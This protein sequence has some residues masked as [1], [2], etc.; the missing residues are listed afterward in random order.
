MILY[1]IFTGAKGR[2]HIAENEQRRIN[3]QKFEIDEEVLAD[4]VD[5]CNAFVSITAYTECHYGFKNEVQK[6]NWF[7]E[8][9]ER[10]KKG[11]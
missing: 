3:M 7:I 1:A 6:A 4:L 8:A 9:Y 11:E 5:I 2:V 10:F